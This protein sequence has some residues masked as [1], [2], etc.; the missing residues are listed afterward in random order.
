ME[1]YKKEGNLSRLG[2]GWKNCK[3]FKNED[4]LKN[5]DDLKHEDDLK[6][7]DFEFLAAIA[8]CLSV[9]RSVC[10]LVGRVQ[11]VFLY[12]VSTMQVV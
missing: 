11:S 8:V 4:Y 2:K 12:L 5:E 10:L 1:G 6:Y 9:W 7:E 3:F